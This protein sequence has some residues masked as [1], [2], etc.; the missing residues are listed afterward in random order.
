MTIPTLII[1]EETPG[2]PFSDRDVQSWTYFFII[3]LTSLRHPFPSSIFERAAFSALE[4]ETAHVVSPF[5]TKCVPTFLISSMT[6][7]L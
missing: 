6:L 5:G 4:Y 2:R 7:S 1:C 3:L